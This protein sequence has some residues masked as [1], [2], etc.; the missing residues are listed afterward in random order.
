MPIAQVLDVLDTVSF[1]SCWGGPWS[2]K[3][4]PGMAWIV[5]NA[6]LESLGVMDLHAGH[7]DAG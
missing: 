7:D 3:G 5:L 6:P 2:Q 1:L 4:G